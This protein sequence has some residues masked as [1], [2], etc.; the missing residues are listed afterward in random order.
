MRILMTTIAVLAISG[1]TSYRDIPANSSEQVVLNKMGTPTASCTKSDGSKRL[2]W[3][4]QPNGQYAYGANVSKN[5]VIDKV[6]SLLSDANFKKLNQGIWTPEDVRCEFG[7]P[8]E[9]G[10]IGLGEKNEVVWTYRYKEINV[11]NN[12]MYIYFGRDGSQ[13]TH[14][15]SGPD[16][17]YD[18]DNAWFFD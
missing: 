15:H 17:R 3:S 1:C 10:R 8:A 7:P 13:V 14:Y 11:W 5:G 18:T 2:I 4:T 9:T 16:P 6:T 12:L